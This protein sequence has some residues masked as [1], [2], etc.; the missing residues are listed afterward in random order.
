[1]QGGVH[2]RLVRSSH[3]GATIR[4]RVS[5]TMKV[6]HLCDHPMSAAPFRLARI[7]NLYGLEARLISRKDHTNE[8]PRKRTYPADLMAESP[9]DELR[10]VVEAAD[11]VHY[12][13]RWQ[14][15]AVFG[16]HPW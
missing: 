12:H 6:L 13:Q 5:G 1:M 9:E 15:S 16:V 4:R 14:E 8:G 3:R 10:P 2:P 7:Q 11:R